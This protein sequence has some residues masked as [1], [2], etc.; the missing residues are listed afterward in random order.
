M[1]LFS[2]TFYPISVFSKLMSLAILNGSKARP[3]IILPAHTKMCE[4]SYINLNNT[5]CVLN[6]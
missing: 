3:K 1:E 6:T 4:Q 2:H 5:M